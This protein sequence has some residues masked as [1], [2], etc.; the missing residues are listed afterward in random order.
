MRSWTPR[1]QTRQRIDR[2]A[3][4]LISHF[5][6]YLDRF[7]REAAGRGGFGGPSLYF[8]YQC[9][10]RYHL[11]RVAEKLK[12]DRFFEYVYATL[13]SWGMH[14]MGDTPTKLCE[15]SEFTA[16]VRQHESA[17][18]EMEGL[19]LWTCD[20]NRSPSQISAIVDLVDSMRISMSRAHLVANTKVLHHVLPNLLPPVDRQYTLKYFGLSPELPSQYSAGAVLGELFPH[21]AR[22]GRAVASVALARVNLSS[23]NWHTSLTKVIDNAILMAAR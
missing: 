19:S 2:Q 16:Q 22:V 21:L 6:D 18:V 3:Q 5:G 9:A 23:M 14:R 20:P 11:L 12:D 10:H 1:E 17:L 8:H 13:A 4:N 7:D 15:F